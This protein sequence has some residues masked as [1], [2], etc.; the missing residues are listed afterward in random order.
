M[1][2]QSVKRLTLGSGSGHGL[3]V[4]EF[5]PCVRLYAESTEPAGDSLSPSLSAP[6]LLTLSLSQNK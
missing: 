3:A 5:K 4:H 2:C 1:E 6:P